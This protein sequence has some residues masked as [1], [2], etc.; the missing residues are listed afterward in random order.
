MLELADISGSTSVFLKAIASTA[1]IILKR[2]MMDALECLEGAYATWIVPR[3][4][5][6]QVYLP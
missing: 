6:E 3:M 5:E 1:T 2:T 4:R